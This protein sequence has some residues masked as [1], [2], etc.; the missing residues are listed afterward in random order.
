MSQEAKAARRKAPGNHNWADRAAQAG[1]PTLKGG[2]RG[3]G[4]QPPDDEE[5][6]RT[7]AQVRYGRYGCKQTQRGREPD[8]V[9][10]SNETVDL[11][12]GCGVSRTSGSEAGRAQ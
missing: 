6:R 12:A 3:T 11:G 5:S 1:R 2:R 7:L 9:S 10:R 8:P 4:D